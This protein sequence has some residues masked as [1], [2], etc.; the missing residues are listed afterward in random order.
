MRDP[1]SSH[2]KHVKPE[3]PRQ[4]RLARDEAGRAMNSAHLAEERIRLSYATSQLNRFGIFSKDTYH[5]SHDGGPA[6]WMR[7]DALGRSRNRNATA[8]AKPTL[9]A[10]PTASATNWW[11]SSRSRPPDRSSEMSPA[12]GATSS[13]LFWVSAEEPATSANVSYPL[14]L[15][16][17]VNRMDHRGQRCAL[18]LVLSGCSCQNR[19]FIGCGLNKNA[20]SPFKAGRTSPECR[21]T[22]VPLFART[23]PVE[24]YVMPRT[25]DLVVSAHA[26]KRVHLLIRSACDVEGGSDV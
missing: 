6:R 7:R 4:G 13:N 16:P 10:R 12:R 20:H 1:V 23:S 21:R 15:L 3:G 14:P 8:D 5:L 26:A 25:Q 22:H 2:I 11:R 17:I 24:R 9:N 18:R 19:L